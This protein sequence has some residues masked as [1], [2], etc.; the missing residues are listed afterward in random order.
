MRHRVE[1]AF[2]LLAHKGRIRA[3]GF[4]GVLAHSSRMMSLLTCI[5]GHLRGTL[6]SPTVLLNLVIISN[7]PNGVTMVWKEARD[8]P[9]AEHGTGA[10]SRSTEDILSST[11]TPIFLPFFS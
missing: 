8:Q 6:R 11:G 9:A 7:V 2:S 1:I 5:C 10:F 4:G 3:G